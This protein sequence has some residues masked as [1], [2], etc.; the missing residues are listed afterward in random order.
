[1]LFRDATSFLRE[2][3]YDMA[4]RYDMAAADDLLRDML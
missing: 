4:A 1:M 3:I 2:P